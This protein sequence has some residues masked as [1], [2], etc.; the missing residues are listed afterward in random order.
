MQLN[1][2][3]RAFEN[4]FAHDEELRFKIRARRNKQVGLWAA[5]KLGKTGEA[6]EKYASEL[7]SAVLTKDNLRERLSNDFSQAGINV[8]VEEIEAVIMEKIKHSRD[9][10]M[11]LENN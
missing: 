8:P 7:V 6:A 10:F 9:H 3:E 2:R 11:E 5:Q 1:D 4:K